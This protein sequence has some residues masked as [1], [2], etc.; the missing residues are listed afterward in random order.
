MID[1]KSPFR[2]GSDAGAT[3]AREVDRLLAAGLL[4]PVL[5]DVVVAADTPSD[6]RLR[7]HAL[8][9]VLPDRLL[10]R[11]VVAQEAA[12]WLWCGGPP[13]RFVDLAVAPGSGRAAAPHL[14]VHERRMPPDDVERIEIA[15]PPAPPLAVTTPVRTAADL[16]RILPVPDGLTEATRLA[17][18]VGATPAEISAC[19]GRMPRARGVARARRLLQ[20]WPP[21]A[22]ASAV[23][24]DGG[25]DGGSVDPLAGHPI[26]VEHALD[27]AHR[28]DD[29][30][31]VRGVSHLER[32]A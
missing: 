15:D 22:T 10:A 1:T 28:G 2:A 12:A 3:Q 8:S 17:A 30:V 5:L 20:D 11:G 27:P 24:R 32:E 29:V 9:L 31:E 4:V 6:Q 19:L 21:D 23:G 7:A 26:G 13:P 25:G 16:L 18:H 14:V